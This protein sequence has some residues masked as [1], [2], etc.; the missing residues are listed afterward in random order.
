[1]ISTPAPTAGSAADDAGCS[2]GSAVVGQGQTRR[3]DRVRANTALRFR[4]YPDRGQ[5]ERL[6]AWS[7]TCRAVWNTALA[8]RIWAYKSARRVTLRAVAQCKELTEARRAHEWLKDLPAQCAQQVLRQ[9]D[10]AYDNFWNPNHPAGFPQFKKK[11][12]RQGIPVPG[13]AIQ[14]RQVSRR[15]AQVHLP[16]IGWV[17]FR[18]SRPIDGTIRNATIGRDGLGWHIA[19]GVHRFE[20][21]VPSVPPGP[22]VGVDMGIACSVFVS[23]EAAARQRPD[24]LTPGEQARLRGLER[25]RARQLAYAKRHNGGRHSNRLRRTI[26]QIAALNARQARR[27]ADWNHKLTTDLA[28]NHGLIAVEDLKVRDMMRS[29]AGTVEQPGR[30]VRQKSGLNRGIADQGWGEV[31]RQLE[32]KTRRRGG[33]LIAVPAA[34]TSQTCRNCGVRDPRSRQG[35]GRLFAC[36]G[37]GHTEHADHNAAHTILDRA[38]ST[39]GRGGVC[40]GGSGGPQS[41]RSPR[42]RG[43]RRGS[44][45]REPSSTIATAL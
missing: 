36:T 41:T 26:G 5:E 35:C 40:R 20:S 19:F 4:V 28:N 15:I 10:T 29:A 45:S 25:R 38:L 39:A 34:G 17:R 2:R 33:E 18:L 42:G 13:Q 22:P 16:K 6:T 30:N 31:R 32:Y 21:V 3:G 44:R 43:T 8:Q 11:S 37:C 7:H 12:H 1:M 27:R 24:L 23:D 9:L 14:V